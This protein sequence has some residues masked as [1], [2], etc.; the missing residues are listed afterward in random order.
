MSRKKTKDGKDC[1][2]TGPKI[3]PTEQFVQN[4]I[5]RLGPKYD[6]SQTVYTGT[7]NKITIICKEHGA[8]TQNPETHLYQGQGCRKCGIERNAE[9]KRYTPEEFK[10]KAGETHGYFYRYDKV[11]YVNSMT[12]V[13]ITCPVHGDFSQLPN[14]HL[15]GNGCRKCATEAS[16]NRLRMTTE[17]F[18]RRGIE[19]HNG[20]YDYSQ[21]VYGKR[22]EDHV[23][24]VCPDHGPFMQSPHGHLSGKGC[25]QCA[26]TALNSD[27]RDDADAFIRKAID[28]Y[29]PI[30]D[31]SQVEYRTSKKKVKIGC[32]EH[33]WFWIKPNGHISSL[34]GCPK[35][36]SS[37]GEM[38]VRKI[39]GDKG[40][41][42]NEQYK[43]PEYTYNYRYDFFIPENRVIIEFHG[44]QHY[45]PTG[46]FGGQENFTKTV[47]RDVLKKDLALSVG[48]KMLYLNYKQL[49]LKQEEFGDFIM[50][51]L[52]TF[53]ARPMMKV[54]GE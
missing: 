48:Y 45:R 29:G 8:F 36:T 18:I 52:E 40:V 19:T 13:I 26:K 39:L 42:F 49:K 38:V 28:I 12:K 46:H 9:R 32:P 22:T 2:K 44:E 35:C 4:C 7:G 21:V 14:A 51:A 5:T 1:K 31:Y 34:Q 47:A 20:K 6:Y 11:E 27:K 23:K 17:E 33:G 43:L 50:K 15:G 41:V 53:K 24:I 16:S 10:D 25:S 3:M 54:I 30:Y 37:K